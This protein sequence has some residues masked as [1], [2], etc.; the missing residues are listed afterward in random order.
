MFSRNC[1][2]IRFC[3][4]FYLLDYTW[5]VSQYVFIKSGNKIGGSETMS[6]KRPLVN[7][8]DIILALEGGIIV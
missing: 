3:G 5:V 6:E 8:H 4:Y 7:I 2:F 1:Q